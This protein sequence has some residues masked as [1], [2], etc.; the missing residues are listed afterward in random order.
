MFT[1]SS[2]NKRHSHSLF[3]Y[4]LIIEHPRKGHPPARIKFYLRFI[5]RLKAV[6]IYLMKPIFTK[7]F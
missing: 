5:A 2:K 6:A 4:I 7:V 1:A 3:R